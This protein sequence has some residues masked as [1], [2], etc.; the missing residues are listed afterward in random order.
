MNKTR[1]IADV[2][3]QIGEKGYDIMF[4]FTFNFINARNF[5]RAA[6]LYRCG[7]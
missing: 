7:G 2:F 6:L 3:G 1:I 4:D 5:K